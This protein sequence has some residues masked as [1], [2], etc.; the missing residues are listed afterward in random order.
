M[1]ASAAVLRRCRP[2][3]AS[4][5]GR[6]HDGLY[7]VDGAISAELQKTA[8]IEAARMMRRMLRVTDAKAPATPHQL[9]R[10]SE[11]RTV[12]MSS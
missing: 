3:M 1:T 8:E 4:G 10:L 9:A 11:I 7:I 6:Q 2:S 12:W 5:E